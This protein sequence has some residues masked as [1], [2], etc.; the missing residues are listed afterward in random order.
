MIERSRVQVEIPVLPLILRLIVLADAGEVLNYDGSNSFIDTPLHD[1]LRERVEVVAA[2]S[3][4]F[5]VQ[6]RGLLGVSVV[7]ASNP[8]AEVVVVLLQAVQRVQLAV[9][10]FVSESREVGLCTLD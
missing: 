8:F 4:L 9:P 1:V 2:A 7:E 5:L 3:R 10:V 6:S